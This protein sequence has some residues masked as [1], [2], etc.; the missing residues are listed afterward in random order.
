MGCNE[1]LEWVDGYLFKFCSIQGIDS[2]FSGA[3]CDDQ[4]QAGLSRAEK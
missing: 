4:S 1:W 3:I 2:L